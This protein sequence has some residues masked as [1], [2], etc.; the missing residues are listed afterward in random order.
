MK[1]KVWS[2]KLCLLLL[3]V[4]CFAVPVYGDLQDEK[5]KKEEMEAE[6]KDTEAYLESL[7]VLKSDNEAYISALDARISELALNIYNLEQQA[8][9]KQAEIDAKNVEILAKEAE[10]E[11]QYDDMAMRIQYMYENGNFQYAEMLLGS[12][13]MDDFLNKAEYIAELTQY[14]RNMLVELENAKLE[15]DAQKVQLEAALSELNELIAEAQEERAAQETL[16]ASKYNELSFV[17]NEISGT[18]A[19]IEEIIEDIAAQEAII[20]ELEELERK[21]QEANLNL[22]YDGGQMKWPLPGYSRLSSYFGYRNNPFGG[23]STEFHSGIDIP[24]P[25]GE[26]ITAAYKGQVAWAYYSGSAGNWVGVDHGNG[27]FTVYMH[28]SG[29]LVQEGD[30]VNIGDPIG[31][32]GSTGRSTGPHLHFS[33][34]VNGS[35]VDPLSYVMI[36]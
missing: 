13:S 8:V 32:V 18:T 29:F 34:R 36:P 31:L 30:Y 11:K 2:L 12:S 10:I 28:M 5:D 20:K 15:L 26:V 23:T 19:N 14:D 25:T 35:Y 7:E 22:T 21:R 4:T 17:N 3:I 16:L 1:K 33:V 9:S 27:I 6:L 24:A